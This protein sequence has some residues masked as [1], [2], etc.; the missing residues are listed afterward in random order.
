MKTLFRIF[1]HA[2]IEADFRR[3]EQPEPG[4]AG[5]WLGWHHGKRCHSYRPHS[6]HSG[7]LAANSS[8]QSF[9]RPEILKRTVAAI[10]VTSLLYCV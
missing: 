3:A 4:L 9:H 2:E 5:R 1:P 10:G 6:S 8:A 7:Q